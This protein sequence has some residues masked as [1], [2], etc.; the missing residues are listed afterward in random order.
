MF[1]E[2][3]G[4]LFRLWQRFQTL[5]RKSQVKKRGDTS[6]DYTS[7]M[8]VFK[9]NACFKVILHYYR[10]NLFLWIIFVNKVCEKNI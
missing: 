8:E 4:N 9:V 7:E 1:S 5:K 3:L 10:Q 2:I 6:V